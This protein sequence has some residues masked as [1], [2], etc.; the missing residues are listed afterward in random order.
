MP[1]E[2]MSQTIPSIAQCLA[3]MDRYGMFD[4]IRAHSLTVARVAET[5]L[6]AM[7]AT[8]GKWISLPDPEL[9]LAGALLH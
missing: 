6:T 7:A 3:L 8:R 5:L 4:N 1:D 2:S 9:V